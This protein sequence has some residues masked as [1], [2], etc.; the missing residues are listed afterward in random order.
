[1]NFTLK[2]EK[3]KKTEILKKNLK[4][5]HFKILNSELIKHTYFSSQNIQ[6]Y[7]ASKHTKTKHIVN[8]ISNS[9]LHFQLLH[10]CISKQ[11]TLVQKSS[12]QVLSFI[13]SDL[14]CLEWQ[15]R[16]TMVH[17]K[18]L[19]ENRF[20]MVYFKP[21]SEN[22]ITMVYFKSLSENRFTMVYFKPLSENRFTMVY[23]TPLSEKNE[24]QPQSKITNFRD[25]K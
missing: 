21:L 1:M 18:P 19:S 13:S 9:K 7:H 6:L 8:Y 20:T 15:D 12:K 4:T 24:E 22:R 23:F 3:T 17:F 11:N 25:N 2:F 14:S 5:W 10:I 16:F